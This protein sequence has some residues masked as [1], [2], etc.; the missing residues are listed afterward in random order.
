MRKLQLTGPTP[1]TSMSCKTRPR[2]EPR[3]VVQVSLSVKPERSVPGES[4]SCPF[5][6]SVG[7]FTHS[8]GPENGAQRLDSATPLLCR[9][10]AALALTTAFRSRRLKAVGPQREPQLLTSTFTSLCDSALEKKFPFSMCCSCCCRMGLF[11]SLMEKLP[12]SLCGPERGCLG[13]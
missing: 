3:T 1:S 4:V 9:L 8:A 2:I 6:G 13:S 5:L 10:A 11:K 7:S 12:W